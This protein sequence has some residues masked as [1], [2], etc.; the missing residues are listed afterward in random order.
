MAKQ[1]FT[2]TA[3]T[4]SAFTLNG[5]GDYHL[6]E[7]QVYELPADNAHIVSLVEQGML[8]P[9]E[10]ETPKSKSKDK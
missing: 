6:H 4:P 5:G 2:Y 3:S 8:V 7:G 9:V 10:P 1:K